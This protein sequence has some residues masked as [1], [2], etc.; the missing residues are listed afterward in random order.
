MLTALADLALVE[1]KTERP[2]WFPRLG[3]DDPTSG[4]STQVTIQDRTGATVA[5]LIVGKRKVDRF[6]GGNDGVYVRKPGSDQAWLARGSL[7]LSGDLSTWLDRRILDI[8][9]KRIASI[10]F[11]DE[12]GAVL[13][14]S[15][16][17]A[18]DKFKVEDAAA[19]AKLKSAAVLAEPA[20]ALTSLDLTDVRPQPD[21]PVPDRDV[22]TALFTTFDGLTVELFLFGRNNVDW[23]GVDASGTGAGSAEAKSI[24]DK[25]SRWTYAI[26]PA[27]A[28]LLRRKL[29]DLIESPSG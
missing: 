8:P 2:Q 1:P 4:Q 23:I 26:P 22:A 10:K 7:D 9:E 6:G 28:K 21:L 29:A 25:V 17:A 15:R 12:T 18:G 19:D 24:T 13:T 27:T 11:T 5:E 14:L 3:L 16:P 20:G